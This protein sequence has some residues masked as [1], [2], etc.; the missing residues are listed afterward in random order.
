[1]ASAATL[2]K[3]GDM[4]VMLCRAEEIPNALREIGRLREL[5]FRQAG[6]GTGKACDLD[7][8]DMHYL[9]LVL[10]NEKE[11]QVAGAYRLGPAN[12]ILSRHGVRGFYTRTLFAWNRRFLKRLGP[13]VELGR[14]FIRPEYQKSYQALLLLWKGI[15]QYLARNPQY[16]VLFGPVSISNDYH[17][18]SRQLIVRFLKSYCL[19]ETLTGLV[20]ARNP[21]G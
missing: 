16:R 11:G 13:A 4:R 17:P 21:F 10:W 20:R 9:H 15:G 1:M 5:T 3:A 19:D 18:D 12:D 2:V 8:F 7:R 6:E 14:S